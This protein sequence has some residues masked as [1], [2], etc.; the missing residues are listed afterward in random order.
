VDSYT[1]KPK[2]LNC[3]IEER[4]L[5]LNQFG[6][7]AYA[8]VEPYLERHERSACLRHIFVQV[9][10]YTYPPWLIEYRRVQ[11]WK[12]ALGIGLGMRP[13]NI[14]RGLPAGFGNRLFLSVVYG[15]VTMAGLLTPQ[16]LFG[17]L[18]SYLYSLAKRRR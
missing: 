10:L 15:F 9:L 7:V 13:R 18:K 6:R 12:Y 4:P 16:A 5:P 3:P 8:A 2:L 17:R 11:S 1:K 14:L